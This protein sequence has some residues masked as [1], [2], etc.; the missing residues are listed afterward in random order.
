VTDQPDQ[1][2]DLS[3]AE[4]SRHARKRIWQD[5]T[6]LQVHRGPDVDED[7]PDEVAHPDRKKKA[8]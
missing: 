1:P 6:V 2:E 8:S 5:E 4:A 7:L 3:P